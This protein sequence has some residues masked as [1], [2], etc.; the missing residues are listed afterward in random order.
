MRTIHILTHTTYAGETKVLRAYTRKEDAESAVEM[1]QP[2]V[3]GTL[4]VIPAG[5]EEI[6]SAE[7]IVSGPVHGI[8]DTTTSPQPS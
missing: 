5:F 6:Q 3:K 8:R 4:E 7:G 2:V 1:L